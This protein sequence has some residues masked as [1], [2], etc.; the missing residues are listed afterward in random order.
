MGLAAVSAL[1]LSACGSNASS[2]SSG[3]SYR[4]LYV[5]GQTGVLSPT[6]IAIGRGIKA[7][8]DAINAEG[9]LDGKKIVLQTKDDQ[10]DPT[11]GV[12]LVQEQL[13]GDNPPDLVIPGVSSNEALAVAPLLARSK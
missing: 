5:A 3:G 9:G 12:T 11:R 13:N 7:H 10:S 4:I 2:G 6:A 8:V 1:A